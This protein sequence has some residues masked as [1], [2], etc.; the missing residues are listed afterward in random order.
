LVDLFL[1]VSVIVIVTGGA[2]TNVVGHNKVNDVVMVVVDG[3]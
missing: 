1:I 2:Y 3:L